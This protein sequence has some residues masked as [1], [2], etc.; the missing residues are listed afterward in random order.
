M[1]LCAGPLACADEP[2]APLR[3]GRRGAEIPS[4]SSSGGTSSSS[5]AP[6]DAATSSSSGGAAA[7]SIDGIDIPAALAECGLIKPVIDV[8]QI[9]YAWSD[10]PAET[11]QYAVRLGKSAVTGAASVLVERVQSETFVEAGE[12]ESGATY[13]AT[14]VAL[15][16]RTPLCLLV[17][18]PSFTFP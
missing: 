1:L 14:V 10:A 5:G 9:Q 13:T 12:R 6:A 4:A 17:G 8:T 11:T 16:E 7:D 15:Q 2:M 3:S 18:E